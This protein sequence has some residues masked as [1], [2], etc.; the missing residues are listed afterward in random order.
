MRLRKLLGSPPATPTARAAA[1][2]I[3][4]DIGDEEE[5]GGG[6]GPLEDG[7]ELPGGNQGELTIAIDDSGQH[8]VIGFNDFRGFVDGSDTL[9]ISGFMWSDDG[10]KTFVDGG[11]LP[12][13]TG[14]VDLG[15]TLLPLVFGDPDVKDLGGCNFI[16][17]SIV[18][19]PFGTASAVQTMGFHR[20]TDC[21]HTWKGPFV[22]DPAS[23]PNGFVD[24]FGNPFDAADKEQIDV[25]RATGRVIVSWT[26]F[27]LEVEISTSY[28]DNVL[29]TGSDVE[30]ARHRRGAAGRRR[31][32]RDAAV[33]S[34]GIESGVHRVGDVDADW[35]GRYLLRALDRQRRQLRASDRPRSRVLLSGSSPR[36]RPHPLVPDAGRRSIARAKS[37]NRVRRVRAKQ[38]S[39]TAETWSCKRSTNNG[40]TFGKPVFVTARPGADRSQWFPVHHHE[41]SHR[42]RTALL[43]RPGHR[44]QRRPLAGQL[45][46]LGRWRTDMGGTAAAVPA[47][48][49]CW[50]GQRHEPAE[51]RGLQP[52]RRQPHGR[53]AGGI[54]RDA[55][56]RIP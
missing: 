4:G 20:S 14:T 17:T 56:G 24:D 13:T 36:Q 32:G 23:N 55:P 5:E 7:G 48:I 41:R 53:F 8:V 52:G 3:G 42:T 38:F 31:A 9:S 29:A 39:T 15:G 34:V 44:R 33:R 46:L 22:I 50:L 1:R 45:H 37:R 35:T 18:I 12:I 16:Y 2:P 21:G 51:S 11:R 28:S 25:D 27:S 10:G 30:P 43:L 54:R 26:N 19:A 6:P 40:K 47:S 49:S